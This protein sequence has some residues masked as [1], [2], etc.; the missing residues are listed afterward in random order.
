MSYKDLR[1]WLKSVDEM[2][3][4]RQVNGANWDLDLR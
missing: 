1:E 3:E 4:L 2:G